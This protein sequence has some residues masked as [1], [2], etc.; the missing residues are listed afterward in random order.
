MSGWVWRSTFSSKKST[1]TTQNPPIDVTH[2]WSDLRNHIF[3]WY[4]YHMILLCYVIKKSYFWDFLNFPGIAPGCTANCTCRDYAT[5]S[6]TKC[7]KKAGRIDAEHHFQT[8][9]MQHNMSWLHNPR[10]GQSIPL[11]FHDFLGISHYFALLRKHWL[12]LHQT[13]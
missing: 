13:W 8:V 1:E 11:M 9:C 10:N 3:K 6:L 7:T 5:N 4:S 12:F 2:A